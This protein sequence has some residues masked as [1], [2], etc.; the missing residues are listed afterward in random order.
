MTNNHLQYQTSL[1]TLFRQEGQLG[2]A[3]LSFI[4][5]IPK[6][7]LHLENISPPIDSTGPPKSISF[8]IF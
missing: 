1:G 6:P 3:K 5:R 4:L 7:Q 2:Q 8:S